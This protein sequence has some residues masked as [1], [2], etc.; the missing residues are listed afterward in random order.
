MSI[1]LGRPPDIPVSKRVILGLPR[2]FE[3][4]VLI[5][6]MIHDQ[7]E[8]EFHTSLVKGIPE[9]INVSD[10]AIWRIN[11]S[12]IADIITLFRDVSQNFCNF[13]L[14]SPEWREW[15]KKLTMSC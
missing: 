2:L 4:L 3:P 13:T 5:A 9:N 10:V 14:S 11:Y 6:G 12:I 1:I 7:V 15:T 8:D